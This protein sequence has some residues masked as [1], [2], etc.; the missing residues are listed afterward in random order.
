MGNSHKDS[1]DQDSSDQDS[2]DKDSSDKD[3]AIGFSLKIAFH[4]GELTHVAVCSPL[5]IRSYLSVRTCPFVLNSFTE[6][7]PPGRRAA[8]TYL[9][10]ELLLPLGLPENRINAQAH[11]SVV[12]QWPLNDIA[13]S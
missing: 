10:M 11:L 4:T 9:S 13:Y 1:S 8:T 3:T 7:P 2:S 6:E 12:G 5:S